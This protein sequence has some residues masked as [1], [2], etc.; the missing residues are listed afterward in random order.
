MHKG[1]LN[2]YESYKLSNTK[3][4]YKVQEKK[5]AAIVLKFDDIIF[6]TLH[7]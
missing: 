7:L 3:M 2:I 5:M 1:N 4:W 6:L